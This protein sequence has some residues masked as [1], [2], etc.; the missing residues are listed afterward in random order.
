VLLAQG[1]FY[2]R[3]SGPV[4]AVWCGLTAIV[5]GALLTIGFLT[6]IAVILV[7][8]EATG[9]ALSML[10]ACTPDLF[11]TKL[12][13]VFA[14]AILMAVLLLGPGALSVDARLFGRRE[15]II[16][17]ISSPER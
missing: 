11:D 9:I 15:V 3:V 7:A 8:L 13:I 14:T 4:P 17:P 1:A 16:P 6:P 5:S 12:P 10:P 2:L